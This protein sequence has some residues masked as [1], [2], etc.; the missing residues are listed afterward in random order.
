MTTNPKPTRNY[1]ATPL[2]RIE[3]DH[4][5]L[6]IIVVD[7]EDCLPLGRLTLR[8]CFHEETRIVQAV[9][10]GQEDLDLPAHIVL[11]RGREFTGTLWEEMQIHC[12]PCPSGGDAP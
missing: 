3:I 12:P 8:V 11:D 9:H 4:T 7:E 10:L 2:E 1:A 5:L 6:D